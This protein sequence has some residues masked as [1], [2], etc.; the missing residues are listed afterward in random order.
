MA[1]TIKHGALG[2]EAASVGSDRLLDVEQV[3]E[4]LRVPVSWVYHHT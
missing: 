3:A 4:L 2:I 1:T